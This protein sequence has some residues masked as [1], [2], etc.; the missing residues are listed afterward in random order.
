M[1]ISFAVGKGAIVS[2]ADS[3][4]CG[5][6]NGETVISGIEV[7]GSLVGTGDVSFEVGVEMQ[8]EKI[9]K[10]TIR[11]KRRGTLE[12]FIGK[13]YFQLIIIPLPIKIAAKNDI[14][15]RSNFSCSTNTFP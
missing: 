4:T 2:V 5:V 14:R 13:I 7:T 11:M 6:A 10:I 9:I 12:N 8:P 1:I 15:S 3:D